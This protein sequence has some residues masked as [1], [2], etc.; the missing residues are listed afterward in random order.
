ML[1]ESSPLVFAPLAAGQQRVDRDQG[2]IY[3]VKI[4]GRQS[5]NR[6]HV[7]GA[8][9]TDYTEQAYRDALPL[10]EG[11]HVY[12][13]HPPRDPATGKPLRQDRP[14]EASLGKIFEAHLQG[15]EVYG[16]LR[17]LKSHP[18]YERVMEAAENESLSDCFA[19][20]HNAWGKGEVK[21][22]RYVISKIEVHSVDLVAE[23]GTNRSLFESR[24]QHTMTLRELLESKPD[25]KP[26]YAQLLHLYEDAGDMEAGEGDDYRDH[27]H[28][29]KKLCED[30]GDT[31]TATAIHKLMKPESPDRPDTEDRDEGGGDEGGGKAKKEDKTEEKKAMESRLRELEARDQCRE[32]CESLSFQPSKLQLKALLSLTDA[33]R[34]AFVKE[35]QVARKGG[36]QSRSLHREPP[37]AQLNESAVP[38]EPDAQLAWLRG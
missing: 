24:D 33:E 31:E 21:N 9:G 8:S 28:K 15:G 6:H 19:L 23:G 29:A 2:V 36:P 25:L 13:G 32:L 30:A 35:Q 38:K 5:I 4:A 18:M 37:E 16:N 12:S 7:E 17:L 26:R 3:G 10:Y 22:G 14:P 34:R 27:L 20:S 1:R 11:S